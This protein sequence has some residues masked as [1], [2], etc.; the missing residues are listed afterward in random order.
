VE[1]NLDIPVGG[2]SKNINSPKYKTS[3][4][5]ISCIMALTAEFLTLQ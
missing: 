3:L 4:S 2:I 1:L 5:I